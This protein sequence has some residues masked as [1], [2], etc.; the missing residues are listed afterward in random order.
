MLDSLL[1]NP[2]RLYAVFTAA[3]ALVAHYATSLPQGLI[4]GLVAAILGVGETVR[5]KVDGPVTAR[6][7]D[8]IIEV[9]AEDAIR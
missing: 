7:K 5:S 1:N 4:L 9:L 8:L 2:V 6:Q 3:L